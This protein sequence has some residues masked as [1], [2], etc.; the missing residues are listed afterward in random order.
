MVGTCALDIGVDASNGGVAGIIGAS[1][2]VDANN[3]GEQAAGIRVT[4]V[5]GA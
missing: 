3:R 2:V 4:S 5:V 1:V